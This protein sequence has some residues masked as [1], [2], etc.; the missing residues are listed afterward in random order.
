MTIIF[1]LSSSPSVKAVWRGI[2][3][4]GGLRDEQRKGLEAQP[5]GSA[6]GVPV[7]DVHDDKSNFERTVD[8]RQGSR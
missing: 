4:I 3:F 6:I 1:G 2:H 5:S 7:K 8:P